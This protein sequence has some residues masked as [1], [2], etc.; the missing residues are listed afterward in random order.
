[1]GDYRGIS[2]MNFTG[3][4]SENWRLWRQKFENYLIASEVSKK[5]PKVQIAQLLHYIGEEGMSIYNTFTFANEEESEKL[6]TVINQFEAHFM[7][8][9][10]LSYERFK[11]FTRKQL[12]GETIE[13]FATDLKNK[14]K[15]C[16]FGDLKESLIKDILTCGL[17][18]QNLRERLLQDDQKTLEEAIQLCLSVESSRKQSSLISKAGSTVPINSLYKSQNGVHPQHGKSLRSFSKK[19]MAYQQSHAQSQ[20]G[21]SNQQGTT[22]AHFNSKSNRRTNFQGQDCCYKCGSKH[23]KYCCPAY[24]RKCEVCGLYNHFAK[25]CNK[26]KVNGVN[27]EKNCE[28]IDNKPVYVYSVDQTY[29]RNNSWYT[30]LL[31]NN[32]VTVCFKLDTGAQANLISMS[33]MK[34]LRENNLI[35][36]TDIKLKSYTNDFLPVIG[37]CF[38]NC[39]YKNV[40][41]LL[42]FFVV[43][44]SLECILG[45]EACQKLNLI[46]LIDSNDK[47]DQ[48]ERG[49]IEYPFKESSV[50]IMDRFS[51][52]F[53]GL[54]CLNVKYH[55]ELNNNVQPVVR[56]TRRIPIPLIDDFKKTLIELEE[57]KIIKK[58]NEPT[59]WVNSLV[60]LRKN[61]G[62]LRVCL[63]PRDLNLAIKREH[64]QLPTLDQIV[65]KLTGAKYFS[66]LDATSGFWQIELDD[67]SA[68]L[69]TFGT[70]YGRYCFLRMPFGIKSAPEVFHKHFKNIFDMDGVE[71]YLDDIIVWGETLD[72]HNL[73]LRKV[74][75]IARKNNVT[76][77][78]NKCKILMSEISFMGHKITSEGYY[79]GLDKIEA[80]KNMTIPTSKKELQRFLGMITY[81][82][83]FIPNLSNLNSPLR[84]LIKKN[85]LFVWTDQHTESFQNLK[86]KLTEA[87]VLQYYDLNKPVVISVDASKDGIGACLLQN[88]LP[89]AYASQ[90]LTETQKRWAQIEKELAAV[91]FGCQKFYEFVYGRSFSVETDHRPLIG[92]FKKPLL[93]CPA[94]LQRMVLQLQKFDFELIYK[95]GKDLFLSDALSRAYIKNNENSIP[96]DDGLEVCVIENNSKFSDEKFRELLK[97]S[98]EDS[99]MCLLSKYIKNGWPNTI[100]KVPDLLRDYYRFRNEIV[101]SNGLLF[102]GNKIIVPK[103]LRSKI[104]DSIHY[105]HFG[106]VKCK[107]RANQSF[108]W[109]GM[110][111]ELEKTVSNCG[112]CNK[113]R[114]NN[115][116]EELKHHE[117]P[118]IPWNKLGIDI[119]YLGSQMFLLVVDY[120]TKWVELIKLEHNAHSISVVNILKTLFGRFGIPAVIISDGGPQFSSL[121]FNNFSKKW[122]FKHIFTS[123]QYPQSNGMVERTKQT[124]KKLLRKA[125]EEDKDIELVLLLY[126]NT[127]L[128]CGFSPA[129]LMFSRNLRDI[130]PTTTEALRPQ[131]VNFQNYNK[132]LSSRKTRE[133]Y[134]YNRS[135]KNLKPLKKNN[136]VRYQD[137]SGSNWKVGKIIDK[138]RER[139]YVIEKE[140]GNQIFRNRRFIEGLSEPETELVKAEEAEISD[141][142]L[143]KLYEPEEVYNVVPS[144]SSG[145]VVRKPERFGF[146]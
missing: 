104:I 30:S 132:T 124:I 6:S 86:R 119:L 94:R 77:N 61:D 136:R 2:P 8:K 25:M 81:V 118:E 55:I 47:I 84:E 112:I 17:Q 21:T 15:S 106:I 10:N 108:F 120:Y 23:E 95:P 9:K 48:N 146:T 114:V 72:E 109:P 133:K 20:K 56:P 5:D 141:F 70:P 44:S 12:E 26:R 11:F 76:F 122:G 31:L 27:M 40:T 89:C 102:K 105:G 28:E 49:M 3:N 140:N 54:G 58:I 39:R 116:K 145:R 35:I 50:A 91:L 7:P 139:S 142:N 73:R 43:D 1:M 59:D 16:E 67:A 82:G 80:I 127:P 126:R 123:A 79:P 66:K 96:L 62:S 29:S 38:L 88:G 74:L 130:L 138:P 90:A 143:S 71:I 68:K 52:R 37:K 100:K 144:T 60:V 46:K 85:N 32:K 128:E 103:G 42:E 75:D 131:N 78:K 34:N 4:L 129:Q 135:H 53:S 117:I 41:A 65:S 97:L 134:Y 13:Q 22:S 69:C 107:N 83:R 64:F 110:I 92:I 14:A 137:Y 125:R 101:V 111:S 113:Y 51:D 19:E 63:D 18:S 33:K 99:E 24:R 57:K 36:Q 98:N 45:L 115:Q 87:P 93:E 121:A